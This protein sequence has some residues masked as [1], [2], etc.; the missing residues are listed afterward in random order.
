[1]HAAFALDTLY[2]EM[3]AC[4]DER[5]YAEFIR[6]TGLH[7]IYNLRFT[8]AVVAQVAA[9]QEQIKQLRAQAPSSLTYSFTMKAR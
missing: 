5:R 8:S 4:T 6:L 9:L 3:N 7:D 1:M 2:R